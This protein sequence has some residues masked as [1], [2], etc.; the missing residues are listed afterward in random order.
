M[1][2]SRSRLRILHGRIVEVLETRRGRAPGRAGGSPGPPRRAGRGMDKAVTYCRQAGTRA[3]DRA[4]F[5]EAAA[6]SSRLS[7]PSRTCP[8]TATP[9]GWPLISTS[10]GRHAA[11]LGE[12]PAPRPV[13]RGR[14]PGQGARRSGPAGTGAGRDGRCTQ[15]H[16]RFRRRHGCGPAGLRTC[17]RARRQRLAGASS[18]ITW[19]RLLCHRR[20]RPGSRA[21]AAQRRGCGLAVWHA[22]GRACESSPRRGWRG[23]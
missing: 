17:S 22:Q 6:S 11:Q 12:C 14:G 18:L 15:A 1:A 3:H 5:R 21:A 19:G 7:R 8:T 20:F 10:F 4:A 13:G 2:C 9:G 23:P 16:G